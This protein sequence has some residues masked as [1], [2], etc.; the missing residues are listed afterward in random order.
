MWF[1][2]SRRTDGTHLASAT[3][4]SG[5]SDTVLQ[6]TDDP[7]AVM[8][9]CAINGGDTNC[10]GVWVDPAGTYNKSIQESV[11]PFR[12]QAIDNPG[13]TPPPSSG[14]RPLNPGSGTPTNT[15][16]PVVQFG[17]GSKV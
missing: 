12:A 16:D 7:I 2:S 11:R 15:G 3:L 4:V 1:Q 9:S 17:C 10:N 6:Y 13:V 14:S 8:H 5:P